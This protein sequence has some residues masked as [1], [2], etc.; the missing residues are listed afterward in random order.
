MKVVINKCYGGFELSTKTLTHLIITKPDSQILITQ[1]IVD[2]YGPNFTSESKEEYTEEVAPNLFTDKL[3]QKEFYNPTTD[4]ITIL[5]PYNLDRTHPD[6]IE[7]VETFQDEA[8]GEHSQLKIVEIPDDVDFI[9][10]DYDGL[11][12]IAEKHRTWS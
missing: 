7:L 12:C 4:T 5:E 10:E 9:I 6:L 8:N 1:S 11:E 2:Y 3:F